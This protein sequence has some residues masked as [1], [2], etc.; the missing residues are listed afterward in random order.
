MVGLRQAARALR[1]VL[2]GTTDRAASTPYDQV[3]AALR[4]SLRQLAERLAA[5]TQVLGAFDGGAALLAKL[6][7]DD[8]RRTDAL[9]PE[10]LLD[11][12]TL[13]QVLARLGPRIDYYLAAQPATKDG[14]KGEKAGKDGL[15]AKQREAAKGDAQ[16]DWR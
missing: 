1:A 5:V 4:A 16:D 7:H 2:E 10:L 9:L 11:L 15:T 6:G 3:G 14:A 8:P 12:D 13:R